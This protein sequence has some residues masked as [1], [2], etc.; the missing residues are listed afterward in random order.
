MKTLHAAPAKPRRTCARPG[1]PRALA[2][3]ALAAGVAAGC[4]EPPVALAG[5]VAPVFTA[6][7]SASSKAPTTPPKHDPGDDMMLGGAAP[8][9]FGSSSP[10]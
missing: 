2:A 10:R 8:Q 5:D 9:P 4:D 1:Y 6:G 3:L 7:A